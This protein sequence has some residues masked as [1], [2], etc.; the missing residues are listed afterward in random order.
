MKHSYHY[1]Y[2]IF[3][4]FLLLSSCIEQEQPTNDLFKTTEGEY[5]SRMGRF[6][7]AYPSK[8]FHHIYRKTHEENKDLVTDYHSI[9]LKL[10][11]KRIFNVEYFVLNEAFLAEKD[12]REI[13]DLMMFDVNNFFQKKGLTVDFFDD[14]KLQS[15]EGVFF[16]YKPTPELKRTLPKVKGEGK[17]I[18]R[19]NTIYYVY[20]L[21]VFDQEAQNFIESF[22]FT[23]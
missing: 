9:F 21:G 13:K 23:G 4:V 22:R 12:L 2:F 11:N 15:F 6:V 19:N 17:A 5:A 14:K 7:A 20:F 3:V 10:D 1:T 18:L 16:S 8:P